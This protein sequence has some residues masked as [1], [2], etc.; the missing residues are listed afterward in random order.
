VGIKRLGRPGD[1]EV[2]KP[3]DFTKGLPGA[4]LVMEPKAM[5]I[6]IRIRIPGQKIWK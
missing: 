5:L 6:P 3:Y 4:F 1:P 2:P